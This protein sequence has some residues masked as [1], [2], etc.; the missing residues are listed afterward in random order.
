M[1]PFNRFPTVDT[2]LGPEMRSTG[3]V[4]GV[5]RT[6]EEAFGRAEEAANI[7]AM[8]ASLAAIDAHTF[9]PDVKLDPSQII[10]LRAPIVDGIEASRL[11][12]QETPTPI[13]VV[14]SA[15]NDTE[16]QV[17]FRAR[18]VRSDRSLEAF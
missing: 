1:L 18:N 10:D 6:F 12:M 8:K 13:V 17:T 9:N 5:G 11:I 2:V 16:L 4:M 14:S 7:A 3:E 15:L